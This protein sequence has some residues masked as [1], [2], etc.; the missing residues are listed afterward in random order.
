MLSRRNVFTSIFNQSYATKGL[1]WEAS[2]D[3]RAEFLYHAETSLRALVLSL[4]CI[5]PALSHDFFGDIVK[6]KRWKEN[7]GILFDPNFDL[8]LAS[9][10]P[11]QTSQDF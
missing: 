5:T 6:F 11:T 4:E 1:H 3:S 9:C 2:L 7:S 10:G 8:G